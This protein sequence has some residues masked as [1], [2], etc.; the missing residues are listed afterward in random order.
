MSL[1]IRERSIL[2]AERRIFREILPRIARLYSGKQLWGAR[3][4]CTEDLSFILPLI[5]FSFSLVLH[6][7]PAM[8]L[9]FISNNG[10]RI[11]RDS[12]FSIVATKAKEPVA[13]DFPITIC[14]LNQNIN[15][16]F[17]CFIDLEKSSVYLLIH[18]NRNDGKGI[19]ELFG[20]V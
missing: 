17:C 6:R 7:N 5:N 11:I 2:R 1:R 9:S 10:S 19:I 4:K 18:T 13:L 3:K 20:E 12:I 14:K 16:L 8:Q 15:N